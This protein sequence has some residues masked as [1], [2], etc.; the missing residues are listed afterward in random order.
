VSVVVCSLVSAL[1]IPA[2]A[3]LRRQEAGANIRVANVPKD[4]RQES[5]AIQFL[6][7]SPRSKASTRPAG[8]RVTFF[9]CAKKGNQRNTP[10]AARLPGILPFRS[11]RLLRGSL[12][13]RPCTFS[14]PAHVVCALLRTDPPHPRRA[15]GGPVG[16]PPARRSQGKCESQG[17]SLSRLELV[18]GRT[19]SWINGAIRG[20][21]HRSLRGK[22]P[23]G[24]G[25][26]S[27]R[28]R[29]GTGTV[30]S[31]RPRDGEKRRNAPPRMTRGGA[32]R[33]APSLLPTFGQCQK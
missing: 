8:E 9:A 21:E 4:T 28:S 29:S 7:L 16:R 23:Q 2:K 33:P 24:R 10:P 6:R 18:Q 31:E 20:A 13:V 32:P 11:A 15:S 22:S 3:G 27:P 14:E 30:P 12:D 25:E 19:D 5:R 1:V 17:L 26:G